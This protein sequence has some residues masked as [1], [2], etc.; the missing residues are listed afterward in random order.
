MRTEVEVVAAPDGRGGTATT[1]LRSAGA[2]A[3]RR[4]GDRRTPGAAA[5]VHLVG[6]AAGP[7]GGDRLH[8]RV[9]VLAGA[10]LVLRGVAATLALPHRDGG[11]ATLALEVEVGEAARLDVAL[12]PVVVARGAD[13]RASTT[14]SVADG[15]RLDLEEQV[16]LGRWREAPGRWSGTTTADLAGRP[17]LRQHLA[18]G[19]G[20]PT[21]DALDA[22][23]ACLTRLST[24]TGTAGATDG[25]GPPGAT[26]CG[27]AA[28]LPLARGGTL[29]E[30]LGADLGAVRRD[31]AALTAPSRAP[32]APQ[33]RRAASRSRS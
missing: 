28:L 7:L 3:A 19:P 10:S 14:A 20:S 16:L 25:H 9:V 1:V 2:L 23:R 26:A 31:A 21:W 18:L 8:L 29:L 32:A 13:L 15:G 11:H 4:T 33:D 24:G 6:T 30:A 27:G 12:Q 5:T 22:P 17:W